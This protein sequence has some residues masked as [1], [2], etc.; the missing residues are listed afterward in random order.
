MYIAFSVYGWKQYSHAKYIE[1]TYNFQAIEI[2]D[3]V[4]TKEDVDYLSGEY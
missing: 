3:S 2:E 1:E 4:E